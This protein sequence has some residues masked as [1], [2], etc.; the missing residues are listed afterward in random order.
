MVPHVLHGICFHY[1]IE[2]YSWAFNRNVD[3]S[4]HFGISSTKD[5][6]AEGFVAYASSLFTFGHNLHAMSCKSHV[7]RDAADVPWDVC[8]IM[9]SGQFCIGR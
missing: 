5:C 2:Q 9:S 4:K 3:F 6:S 7:L 8:N 1:F